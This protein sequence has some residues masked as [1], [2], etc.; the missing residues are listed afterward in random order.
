[1]LEF[2]IEIENLKKKKRFELKFRLFRWANDKYVE[3][4]KYLINFK[5]RC[6][7]PYL[8]IYILNFNLL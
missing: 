7:A 6:I 8:Y 2:G 3:F 1:L 4:Y 5:K